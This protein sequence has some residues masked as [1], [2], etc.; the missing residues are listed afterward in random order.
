MGIDSSNDKPAPSQKDLEAAAEFRAGI[1][2]KVLE[3]VRATN[4]GIESVRDPY[5]VEDYFQWNWEYPARG[6]C[7]WP[8]RKVS[9]A[10]MHSSISWSKK[11][12]AD[13]INA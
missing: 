10:A 4:P 6:I 7:T 8:S 11:Q 13:L 1:H 5:S 9:R 12:S 2:E 3:K